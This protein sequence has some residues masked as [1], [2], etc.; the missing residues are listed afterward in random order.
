MFDLDNAEEPIG[1]IRCVTAVVQFDGSVAVELALPGFDDLQPMTFEGTQDTL[2]MTWSHAVRLINLTGGDHH[3]ARC[4][5]VIARHVA[6]LQL[7]LERQHRRMA[8]QRREHQEPGPGSPG[9]V[10]MHCHLEKH[11]I[12]KRRR[13]ATGLWDTDAV[14]TETCRRRRNIIEVGVRDNL[15]CG[16]PSIIRS[17][18]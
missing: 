14:G 9:S 6:R 12:R 18:K 13:P 15:R 16:F 7:D 8:R 3:D 2:M 5:E 10:G 11:G 17:V 4:R 1:V